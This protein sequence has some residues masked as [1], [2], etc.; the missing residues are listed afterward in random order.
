MA[1]EKESHNIEW[2]QIWRDEY[3]KW[4]CGFANAQG[5]RIYIGKDD[6]GEIVG[7][8]NSKKLLEDLPNKIRDQLGLVP[9]IN[10]LNES[11]REYL[12][13]IV[14]SSTVPISLRGSY[15][16]RSGSVKQELKGHAL[17]NFL[18][19]KVGMTWDRLV[20]ERAALNDIDE[21]SIEKFKMDAARAGRL[22]DLSGLSVEEILTKLRLLTRDGLTNAALVIFGKDPGMFFPNLFVK[23][24]R[25]V[26]SMVDMRFQEV[27]EGN[28][29]RLLDDVMEML[30]KKFLI[31]P[32]RF[33]GIRRIEEL[34]YPKSALREM[35]LNA[36]VH[37]D[38]LG[39]MT[40]IK[41]FDNQI[42]VWNSGLLPEE[43]TIQKLFKPHESVPRN[44]LIAE[45]CY[46]VGYI[47]SRG[48][49]VEKITDACKQAG[50]PA[51]DIVER[52]GG[53]AV[54][55]SQSTAAAPSNTDDDMS[56]KR[57]ESVGKASGKRRE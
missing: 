29:I 28:L 53:I 5:G 47:D 46:K 21:S 11:G 39:S 25:F 43:L 23:I 19:K 33:E 45:V 50:L 12:E 55:L 34:E 49:G 37:R 56:G 42:S 52:T 36:L 24:G 18:L 38:Y 48:R 17:T 2:K 3:L 15:Y 9:S 8:R 14:D 27:C 32:I 1:E 6:A 7:L 26:R 16:W 57:R 54:E 13:I 4:I 44:P 30:E 40:Q 51:P 10:L 41:V 20:E 31:K 22:P 35:L